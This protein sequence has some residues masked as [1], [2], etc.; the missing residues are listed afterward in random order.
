MRS[1]QTDAL[2]TE[3]AEL[4]AEVERLTEQLRLSI[5][6][7]ATSEGEANDLRDEIERLTRERD[8]ARVQLNMTKGEAENDYRQLERDK[9]AEIERLEKELEIWTCRPFFPRGK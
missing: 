3:I 4:R 1:K 8:E 9:D 6:D 5:I 7:A 2:L